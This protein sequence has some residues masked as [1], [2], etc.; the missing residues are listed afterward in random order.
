MNNDALVSALIKFQAWCEDNGA[1]L[2]EIKDLERRLDKADSMIIQIDQM[3]RVPA[4]EYIPAVRDVFNL[5][6]RY[7]ESA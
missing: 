7:W 6:D 1:L 4:A 5:V 2:S 3:L